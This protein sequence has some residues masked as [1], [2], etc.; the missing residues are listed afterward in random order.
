MA[1]ASC[2]TYDVVE[3]LVK[4]REP[5]EDLRVLCTGEQLPD[6]PYTFT[7]IHLHYIAY[8]AI[9]SQNLERAI[10]LSEDKYCSVISSLRPGVPITHDFEIIR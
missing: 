7:S 3:I 6:P 8:G 2:A 5:L 4:Q 10:C 1:V 9:R